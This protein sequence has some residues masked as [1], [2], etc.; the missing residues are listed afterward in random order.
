MLSRKELVDTV[1]RLDRDKVIKN[2]RKGEAFSFS[3]NITA[4]EYQ[5]YLYRVLEAVKL[6][7]ELG[8]YN[9]P[10]V[11]PKDMPAH[12]F[13]CC[14]LVS[15]DAESKLANRLVVDAAIE[16]IQKMGY[17]VVE[18]GLDPD[19]ERMYVILWSWAF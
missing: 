10:F 13:N 11:R 1:K 6:Y 2:I 19:G 3:F 5:K 15:N 18:R 16:D 17:R 4:E 8:E 12:S 9:V 7:Y 14:D